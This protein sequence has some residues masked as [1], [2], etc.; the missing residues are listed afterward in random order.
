M[1]DLEFVGSSHEHHS[2]RKVITLIAEPASLTVPDARDDQIP[3]TPSSGNVFADLGI[4]EPAEALVKADLARQVGHIIRQRALTQTAAAR[5]LGVD[6]PKIS[7]L[8]R[9]RL[10]GYTIDRL[11]RYAASLDQQV[12]VVLR[13]A[14][15][16]PSAEVPLLTDADASPGTLRDPLAASGSSR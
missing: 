3:V 11:V 12:E 14:A 10:T 6:Q 2:P 5:L 1:K 15:P 8:L 4:A 7:A 16:H 9:G 13:P